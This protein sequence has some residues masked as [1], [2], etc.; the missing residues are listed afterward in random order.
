MKARRW[1][2]LLLALATAGACPWNNELREYLSAHFWLPF[3]KHSASF[4]HPNVQRMDAPYAGMTAT[5]GGSPLARLRAAYQQLQPFDDYV[6]PPRP[7]LKVEPLRQAVAAARADRGLTARDK[8][9]VDLI[10]AKIE[11]RGGECG[12]PALLQSAKQRFQAFLRTA[13][14]PEFGSEA[15]GWLART[16]YLLGDQTAAGKIYLDEL[17]RPGS[18][19]SRETLLNSL[20]MNYGYDGGEEL[21]EHLD[22]Y[23]DTPEHAA[24]AIQLAT[25]PRGSRQRYSG[26]FERPRDHSEIYRR[27][28]ALL[29]S[30]KALLQSD[31]GANTLALLSMRTALRM[32]DPAA[33]RAI[34]RSIPAA[35]AIRAAPDF[36]WMSASAHFLS[37]EYAAAEK[38]LLALFRSPRASEDQRAAAA[39]ALCGVY[40]KTRNVAG[41]LRYALWLHATARDGAH[42]SIARTLADLSIYWASSGWDLGL[43]LENE[44][45]LSALQS[46]VAQNP[47]WP[48]I[49]LV[50]YGLAV[51]LAREDHYRESAAVYES[52]QANRRAQ[53]MRK[54]AALN[55]AAHDPGLSA[56][57]RLEARY[58]FAAYLAA[59]PVR[60]YFNDT[61]WEGMQRYALHAAQESRMT[62]AE[63]QALVEGERKLRDSQEEGWRAYLILK[64]VA[65]D[66]GPAP[67]R[68]RA[69]RLALSCLRGINTERFGREAEIASANKEMLSWLARRW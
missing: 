42:I 43:I 19:L 26:R 18:N 50:K 27:I 57:A 36:L 41:Q 16:H 30:H 61:L 60:L 17:N 29:A 48:D 35:A 6:P 54:L 62:G 21:V 9:E 65:R 25:N 64:E 68:T 12:Q 13:R 15:R 67:L 37:R 63:R 5:Q 23:F 56:E 20:Q 40:E 58:E 22:E 11:M 1:I 69:A 66:A 31:N 10:E 8:E 55:E 46:F 4:E 59:N 47:N 33:A 52:I 45:P 24:F 2:L 53:R 49:R 51:R 3:A 7:I 39:Y 32:G 14:T 28:Q 44:A 38:P 34:D